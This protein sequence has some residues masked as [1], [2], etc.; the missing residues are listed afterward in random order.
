MVFQEPMNS[1]NPLARIGQQVAEAISLHRA[2]PPRPLRARVIECCR[3][4]AS[5]T[6]R[7][8][9]TRSR[10]SFPAASASAS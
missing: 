3:N 9:W 5:R 4:A 1:L 7:S 6:P 2:L 8:G 10:T